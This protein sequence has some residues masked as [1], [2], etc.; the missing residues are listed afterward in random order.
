MHSETYLDTSFPILTARTAQAAWARKAPI[1]T[2]VASYVKANENKANSEESVISMQTIVA[3]T[4]KLNFHH[5]CSS[6][7]GLYLV[8]YFFSW[9]LTLDFLYS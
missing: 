7:R 9:S 8:S 1:I 4:A 3:I 2:Q 6:N 5:F